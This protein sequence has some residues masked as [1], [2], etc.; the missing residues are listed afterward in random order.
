M[1]K[2][3]ST[4]TEGCKFLIIKSGPTCGA[5]VEALYSVE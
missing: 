5:T 1:A 3:V 2:E 4:L